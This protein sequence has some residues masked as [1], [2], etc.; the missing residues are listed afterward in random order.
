M[1]RNVQGGFYRRRDLWN[2][3][4]ERPSSRIECS[5]LRCV[6][7]QERLRVAIQPAI[8][9]RGVSVVV[10]PG[11]LAAEES[12]G[13]TVPTFR[14]ADRAAGLIVAPIVASVSP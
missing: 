6:T 2:L 5:H 9:R 10:L 1:S 14:T 12:G 4:P 8:G 13:P 3:V 11:D 7:R